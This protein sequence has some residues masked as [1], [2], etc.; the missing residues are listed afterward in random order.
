M[1]CVVPPIFDRNAVAGLDVSRETFERLLDYSQE[2]QKWSRTINLVSRSTHDDLWRRHILDSAQLFDIPKDP[3]SGWCDLGS[4]AGLPGMVVAILARELRPET[5]HSLIESDTRKAAFLK[6]QAERLGL[7]VS[8]V[9][10]RI[11]AAPPQ[12]ADVVSARALAPLATLL[13]LAERHSR[14]GAT[15]VFPK[16]KTYGQELA[17]A[18]AQWRFDVVLKPSISNSEGKI[19]VVT[20]LEAMEPSR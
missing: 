7:R 3:V 16:G 1:A 19:L 13:R 11:E 18:E 5:T 14:P 8:I 6:L 2:V 12:N 9:T 17:G 10:D 15:L 20:N 4:G